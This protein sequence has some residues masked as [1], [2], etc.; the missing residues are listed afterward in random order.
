MEEYKFR[1]FRIRPSM[2]E[3]V[4]RYTEKHC[5]VGGFLTAVICNDLE[6]ACW[7]ADDENLRNIP[8]FVAYFYNNAPSPC[9]GSKEKMNKWLEMGRQG[10]VDEGCKGEVDEKDT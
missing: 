8:A 3:A 7:K 1:G 10:E 9:W 2:L 4:K 6:Q 5:P